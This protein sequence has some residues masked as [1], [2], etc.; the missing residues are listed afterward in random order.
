MSVLIDEPMPFFAEKYVTKY[1]EICSK[2]VYTPI[3]YE[4]L[5]SK[6]KEI[7]NNCFFHK[8]GNHWY[9]YI[10]RGYLDTSFVQVYLDVHKNIL[11]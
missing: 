9:K 1:F 4:K 6:L 10:V 11:K 5:K 2:H 7:I 8:T 3:P